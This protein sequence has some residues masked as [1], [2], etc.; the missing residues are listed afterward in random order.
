MKIGVDPLVRNSSTNFSDCFDINA[1]RHLSATC[2]KKGTSCT[3]RRAAN[4]VHNGKKAMSSEESDNTTMTHR[5][6]N[7]RVNPAN[8]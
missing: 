8:V 6:Q 7:P 5:L 1:K 4:T 3:V 2:L